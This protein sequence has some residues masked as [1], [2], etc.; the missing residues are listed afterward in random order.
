MTVRDISAPLDRHLPLWPGSP[1][2][3]TE[4]TQAIE[5]GDGVNASRLTLDLHT[6]TH[7]DAPLHFVEEG[8]SVDSI[9]LERL[10]GPAWVADLTSVE[11]VVEA[12]DLIR[13][14]IPAGITRLLLRTRN[15]DL[16]SSDAF[17]PDYVALDAEAARWIVEAGIE[18][19]GIDY[20]SIQKYDD[21]PEV[22][23][24][25]LESGTVILEGIDL[26]DVEGDRVYELLC[27]PLRLTGVE[28]APARAV[29]REAVD[30]G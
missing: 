15:S 5:E 19:V 20:L 13:A 14:E 27:L 25:L 17:E 8:R 29:L 3:E 21:G 6:G 16:W 1:G 10:V 2:W 28:A 22:H 12:R 9:A 11:T 23:E 24:I 18:L 30:G 26:S 4:R 7:V